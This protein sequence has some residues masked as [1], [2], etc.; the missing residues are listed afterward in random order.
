MMGASCGGSP[1]AREAVGVRV[2]PYL[3]IGWMFARYLCLVGVLMVLSC[4]G[5]S[6]GDPPLGSGA[7]AIVSV[8]KP[9]PPLV[10]TTCTDDAAAAPTFPADLP[11][12]FPTVAA[13]TMAGNFSATSNGEG[14]FAMSLL[15]P[16]GRAGLEPHLALTYSSGSNGG[17]LG[18]GFSIAGFSAVS[19]CAQNVA[20]DGNIRAVQYDG[21]DKLCLD[22]K[23]LVPISSVGSAIEYRVFPDSFVKVVG[24]FDAKGAASFDVY[25]RSGLHVE[26]GTTDDSKVWGLKGIARAWWAAKA[27]DQLGNFVTDSYNNDRDPADHHTVEHTPGEIDYTGFSGTPALD[28]SR[29]VIFNYWNIIL[30]HGQAA[31]TARSDNPGR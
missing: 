14:M 9:K 19:R 11:S 23:R 5:S 12:P 1:S 8:L 26:Y 3:R 7:E 13:G 31:W 18:M 20:Q 22:G 6:S 24:H 17:I 25:T 21:S 28:P 30:N 29:R 27:T 16:P 2:S 15:T 10:D 4:H